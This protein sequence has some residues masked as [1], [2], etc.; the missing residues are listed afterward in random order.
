[1]GTDKMKL[2]DSVC[3]S[4][5]ATTKR[6]NQRGGFT[7]VCA[8]SQLKRATGFWGPYGGEWGVKDC[9]WG[10]IHEKDG[11]VVEITLHATFYYPNGSFE[12]GTDIAYRAGGDSRKK[13]LTDLTTKALS[14]LGF[15]ADIFEGKFDDN[16]YVVEMAA[17]FTPPKKTQKP[18]KK[19]PGELDYKA[20][21]KKLPLMNEEEGKMLDGI[22]ELIKGDRSSDYKW[23]VAV[24][25]YNILGRRWPNSQSDQEKVIDNISPA[26]AK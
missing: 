11:A 25:A 17:K 13:L 7:A 6:V 3:E 10:L 8:Q 15:N 19:A 16:K 26:E 12:L 24:K 1:M 2:W 23:E 22:Y 14:K 21:F 4:D 5:P 20:L 18:A 9:A